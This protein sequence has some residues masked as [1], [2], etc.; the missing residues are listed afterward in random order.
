VYAQQQFAARSNKYPRQA[1]CF[2]SF[3]ALSYILVEC[4]CMMPRVAT[5]AHDAAFAPAAAALI[6]Q[7]KGFA[8]HS[9]KYEMSF[10]RRCRSKRVRSGRAQLATIIHTPANENIAWR[11]CYR[12]VNVLKRAAP[13]VKVLRNFAVFRPAECVKTK[14]LRSLPNDG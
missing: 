8:Q 6:F 2:S 13:A 4:R 5:A 9:M 3:E 12:A 11:N 14:L 1:S 7:V 10:V